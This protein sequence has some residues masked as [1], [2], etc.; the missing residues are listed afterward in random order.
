MLG[1]YQTA[2]SLI[3]AQA[4]PLVQAANM[5]L[6]YSATDTAISVAVILAPLIA[7]QLYTRVPLWIYSFSL[8]GILAM[9]IISIFWLPVQSQEII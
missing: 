1:S 6:A 3:F 8:V 4:R 2:R 9:L 7:S 5:G